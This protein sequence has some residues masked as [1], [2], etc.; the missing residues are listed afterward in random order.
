MNFEIEISSVATRVEVCVTF[1]YLMSHDIK[2]HHQ[3]VK[4]AKSIFWKDSYESEG[5]LSRDKVG[6]FLKLRKVL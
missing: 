3:F 1:V 4:I 6:F 2:T 5:N